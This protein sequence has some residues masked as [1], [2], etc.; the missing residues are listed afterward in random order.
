MTRHDQAPEIIELA[1][2][3]GVGGDAPVEDILDYCR[4]RIDGWVADAGG[5]SNIDA[6]ETLVTQRLQMVF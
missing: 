6:L 1:A 5:V 2:E 4:R 3:L